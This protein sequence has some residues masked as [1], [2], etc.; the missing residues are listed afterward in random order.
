MP[1]FRRYELNNS[2]TVQIARLCVQEQGCLDGVR[3]EASQMANLL[4][5]NSTYRR[6]YGTDIYSF[7]RNSGWYYKAPYYMEHG[8]ASKEAINAVRDVLCEGKRFYPQYVD[9]HDCIVDISYI[10]L[11]GEV[12]DKNDRENYRRGQT[13]II[14]KM[15]SVYTFYDFPAPGCDPFGYTVDAY[16][17]VKTHSQRVQVTC[18]LPEIQQGDSGTAV[19]I[20]QLIIG[21]DPDGIFG[22]KTLNKT[23]Q[24]QRN[25]SLSADGKVGASSWALGLSSL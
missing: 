14:N 11:H 22:Q 10:K 16:E 21:V 5:T 17:Y 24:F 1:D 23:K 3:A 18:A 2:E 19:K 15:G 6:K 13:I 25:Y 20:W 9:E 8:K 12:V 7:V 4:E